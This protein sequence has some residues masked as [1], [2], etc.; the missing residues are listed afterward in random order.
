[1][2]NLPLPDRRFFAAI[3]VDE[4][5]GFACLKVARQGN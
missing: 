4:G 5:Q 3:G 1:M 2:A